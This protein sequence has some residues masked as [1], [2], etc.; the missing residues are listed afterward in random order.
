MSEHYAL[1]IPISQSAYGNFPKTSL[2]VF[3]IFSYLF[4][5]P[6]APLDDNCIKSKFSQFSFAEF[7]K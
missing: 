2:A 6:T 5:P 1:K 7:E 3:S 4:I